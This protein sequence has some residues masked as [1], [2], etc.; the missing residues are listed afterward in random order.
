MCTLQRFF[1][2][3]CFAFLFLF[4]IG[5]VSAINDPLSK[6]N[7][8]FGI[9]ILFDSELPDAGQLVNSNDGDWGYVVI[10]IQAGDRD[11]DKWQNFMNMARNKHL[12]PIIRLATEGDYFNTKVWRKPNYSDVIDFANFLNSLNWPTENRYIIVFNEV[13]RADEWGGSVNPSEYADLLSYAV[14]VFKSKSQNFF[15]ISA[16]LDNAAP[17]RSDQYMNQYAFLKAMNTQV[18][19]IF[20]QLDGIASH[21]YPNPAF[22]QSPKT[23]TQMSI[24][25]FAYERNLV[26]TMTNNK[27]PVFITETGWSSD[28]ISD[29]TRAEYY[30]D[31]FTTVWNDPDI[32]VVAPFLL[33]AG[34]GPYKMF[35]FFNEDGSLTEQYKMFQDFQK[36]KG[37]P[38]LSQ[39]VLG[40]HIENRLLPTK[41]FENDI[42][43][44][45]NRH[46]LSVAFQKAVRW[47]LRY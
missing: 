9:H 41:S 29:H 30:K 22:A 32:V 13:N 15:M 26:D 12:I 37:S 42:Q 36:I 38:V 16:G 25:S 3:F 21:A 33:K 20:N 27:L 14:T 40:Y 34:G 31:A 43:V 35:S 47:I 1:I 7:N 17:N 44:V 39:T 18:P 19:G 4:S 45:K 2:F 46:P 5:S 6:P 23:Q 8:K 28:S 24:T 11:L 10:P